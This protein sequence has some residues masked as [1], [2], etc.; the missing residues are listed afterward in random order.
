MKGG[1]AVGKV[2]MRTVARMSL[3]HGGVVLALCTFGP[4][5]GAAQDRS[6][7]PAWAEVSA[8]FD[9]RCVMCHS[10]VAGASRGLRL[11]DYA[12]ALKG[13]ERGKV[14]I[15]GDM[16]GSELIRRLR[17]ESVP[18]MPFLGR[19]LPEDEI[20]VISLWIEAGLPQGREAK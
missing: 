7:T 17:G 20:K 6:A 15:P 10:A 13:S 1:L 3:R 8:I 16:E 18:R 9:Q 12:A 4:G 5:A 2:R 14:L 19:P 11:D